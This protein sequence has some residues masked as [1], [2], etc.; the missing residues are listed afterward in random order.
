MS[1]SKKEALN[2]ASR[3]LD[4]IMKS[5]LSEEAKRRVIDDSV[6]NFN[7]H[8]NPGWLLYRKSVSTDATFVEW[9]DSEENFGDV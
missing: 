5:D 7:Q 9:E 3:V 1:S 2:Q 8:V 4:Y 6:D